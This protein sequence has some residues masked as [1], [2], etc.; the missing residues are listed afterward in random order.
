MNILHIISVI[1][2]IASFVGV[3]EARLGGSWRE[4]A[5][6]PLADAWALAVIAAII[7]SRG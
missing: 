6:D 5:C 1:L 2:L 3:C 7:C 4:I